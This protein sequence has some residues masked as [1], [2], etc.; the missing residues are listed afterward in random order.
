MYLIILDMHYKK[1]VGVA[2]LVGALIIPLSVAQ[3]QSA[4]GTAMRDGKAKNATSTASGDGS[5]KAEEHRSAVAN[6]AMKLAQTAD[7][8]GG[9]GE[10]IRVVAKEQ[11]ES[12]ERA[13]EAIKN[14]ETRSSLKT[15]L[16]GTDWKSVGALRSEMVTTENHINRLMAA[17]ERA[18]TDLVKN[19]IQAEINALQTVRT[20]INSFIAANESKVSL[21]GWLVR[22][23]N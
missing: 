16:I 22:L 21:L 4:T 9:I 13:A 3:A 17:K 6:L 1:S 2:I 11:A 18:S 19:E 7:K 12:S 8:D 15:F 14:V 23:F 10:E 20:N 5:A